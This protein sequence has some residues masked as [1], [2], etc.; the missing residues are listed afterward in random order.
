MPLDLCA[1]I[2]KH[3]KFR[4]SVDY[5]D[6]G[7]ELLELIEVAKLTMCRQGDGASIPLVEVPGI[8]CLALDFLRHTYILPA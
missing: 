8:F 2:S 6:G 3:L 5:G 7:A 4:K 1:F